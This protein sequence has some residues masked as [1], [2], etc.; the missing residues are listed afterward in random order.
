M[1]DAISLCHHS[2]SLDSP[3]PYH[4]HRPTTTLTEPV[5]RGETPSV[6]KHTAVMKFSRSMAV[7]SSQ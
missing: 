2:S 6:C 7:T 4:S 1:T 3:A 5:T